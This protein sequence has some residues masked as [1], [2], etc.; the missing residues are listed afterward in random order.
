MKNDL[1]DTQEL[2][3]EDKMFLAG[4]DIRCTAKAAE[5]DKCVK[6]HAEEFVG[7]HHLHPEGR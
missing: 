7:G 2:L 1:S 5:Y 3:L 4:L 6:T